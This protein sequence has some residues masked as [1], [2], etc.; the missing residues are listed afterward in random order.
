VTTRKIP[1]YVASGEL[2]DM[3][4]KYDKLLADQAAYPKRL[5]YTC[6]PRQKVRR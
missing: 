3:R 4:D 1:G 5:V 6:E 2:K